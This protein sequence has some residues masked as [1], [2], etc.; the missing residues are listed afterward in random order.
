MFGVCTPVED[1]MRIASMELPEKP[2]QWLCFAKPVRD[3]S[4]KSSVVTGFHQ[5]PNPDLKDRELASV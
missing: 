1:H 2:R 5:H 3:S 4:Q